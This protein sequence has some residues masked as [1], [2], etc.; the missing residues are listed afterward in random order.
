MKVSEWLDQKEKENVDLAQITLPVNLAFDED[1][2]E[3]IF[4]QEIKPCGLLCTKPHPYSKVARFGHW[5]FCS[6][7][8]KK[9]GLHSSKMKWHLFTK[10]KE[11][12]LQTAKAHIE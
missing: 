5:Y 3:I 11:L 9:A 7:Q 6:G 12:A 8:D 2:D 10:D 1:P 4:F